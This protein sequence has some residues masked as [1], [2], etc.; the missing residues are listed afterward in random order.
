V[1][2]VTYLVTLF[3]VYWET[4]LAALGNA[5]PVIH[6]VKPQ[7]MDIRAMSSPRNIAKPGRGGNRVRISA[8]R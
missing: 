2:E 8:A 6:R 7:I 4:A 5:I 3:A 1:D